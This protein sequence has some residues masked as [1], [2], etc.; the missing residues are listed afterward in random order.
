M[1]PLQPYPSFSHSLSNWWSLFLWLLLLHTHKYI[2]TTCWVHSVWLVYIWLQG[3]PCCIAKTFYSQSG[4]MMRIRQC[5][6][7]LCNTGT[8]VGPFIPLWVASLSPTLSPKS[9]ARLIFSADLFLLLRAGLI[10]KT[11]QLSK[12]YFLHRLGWRLC[13]YL[14]KTATSFQIPPCLQALSTHTQI[15]K[16][17]GNFS[18]FFF[19]FDILY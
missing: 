19:S 17:S 14:N 12:L 18:F 9:T 7:A 2:H 16:G 15:N 1:L 6:A 4:E 8:W 5:G 10:L 13:I 11:W 3:W